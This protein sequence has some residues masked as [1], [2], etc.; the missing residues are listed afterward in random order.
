MCVNDFGFNGHDCS[1]IIRF[2]DIY[3][4][5]VPAEN[6]LKTTEGIGI[7]YEDDLFYTIESV[8]WLAKGSNDKTYSSQAGSSFKKGYAYAVRLVLRSGEGSVFS[9]NLMISLNGENAIEYTVALSK[10]DNM[11]T[12]TVFAGSIGADKQISEVRLYPDVT[13]P[14]AGQKI[15]SFCDVQNQTG[16]KNLGQ[17]AW[18]TCDRNNPDSESEMAAWSTGNFFGGKYWF[19]KV[20]LKPEDG[21]T[22]G[23]GTD[24]YVNDCLVPDNC[25]LISYNKSNNSYSLITFI[26]YI[27]GDSDIS[28]VNIKNTVADPEGRTVLSVTENIRT[29]DETKISVNRT[30]CIAYA[31]DGSSKYVYEDEKIVKGWGYKLR[32]ILRA[33]NGYLFDPDVAAYID[34]KAAG[35]ENTRVSGDRRYLYVDIDY[36]FFGETQIISRVDITNIPVK[37]WDSDP[38]PVLKPEIGQKHISIL[39]AEW[40]HS[41]N[42]SNWFSCGHFELCDPDMDYRVVLK[43]KADYG[44]EI[45]SQNSFYTDYEQQQIFG[46]KDGNTYLVMI[47]VSNDARISCI[48]E[49]CFTGVPEPEYGKP[50]ITEGPVKKSGIKYT[51]K[52][53]YNN[54]SSSTGTSFYWLYSADGNSWKDFTGEYFEAGYY[55]CIKFSGEI[56]WTEYK[57]YNPDYSDDPYYSQAFVNGVRADKVETE[58]ADNTYY[59]Y[60]F[61]KY[62][63]L[64]K[65]AEALNIV[66]LN[67]TA[68]SKDGEIGKSVPALSVKAAKVTS[69]AWTLAESGAPASG[70]FA[71]GKNYLLTVEIEPSAGFVFTPMTRVLINGKLM[72]I[73]QSDGKITAVLS[74]NIEDSFASSE[75][76]GNLISAKMLTPPTKVK[77]KKG[78]E[79]V[80]GGLRIQ[81]DYE[82]GS[83]CYTDGEG[84]TASIKT[85]SAEGKQTV[86]L[87]FESYIFKYEITVEKTATVITGIE[88]TK[89]PAKTTYIVGERLRTAGMEVT[90]HTTNG[91]RIFK[92][93]KNIITTPGI[94]ST[95]G[96]QAVTV[97]FSGKRC[98]FNVS[99]SEPAATEYK[100]ISIERLP[101]RTKYTE[102]ELPDL[103]GLIVKIITNKDPVILCDGKD[104]TV[105]GIK[106]L[107]AGQNKIVLEYNGLTAEFEIE[108]VAGESDKSKHIHSKGEL[109]AESPSTCTKTGMKAHYVCET[110]GR[111]LNTDE[112]AV[113]IEEL[114]FPLAP[115]TVSDVWSNNAEFHWKQCS[116]CNTVLTARYEHHFIKDSESC[117][118]CGYIKKGGT[119]END[120]NNDN[121][122]NNENS[123][124][125]KSESC[126]RIWLIILIAVVAVALT[127]TIICMVRKKKSKENQ[128]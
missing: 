96:E 124:G 57:W 8:K 112:T 16:Y 3:G 105:T 115:H 123:N 84:V 19:L 36:G 32:I 110:C 118:T 18:M 83:K 27:S 89:L 23:F 26:K 65:D 12:V 13:D 87:S 121:N 52:Y 120:N 107:T 100:S 50:V 125:T 4:V 47:S 17:N 104:I 39:S 40:Q 31:P 43:I 33:E 5:P 25:Y 70:K 54:P 41:E 46:V 92:D 71:A 113:P 98:S 7:Y 106:P 94:F 85:A 86:S 109:I 66:Q 53:L 126:S 76:L 102:G 62:G 72:S 73:T 128:Q 1:K 61:K 108:A 56:N 11:A 74:F 15:N 34:G 122:N 77:Y 35:K 114:I 79:I 111:Y 44:Y 88:L 101:F 55:Y 22:F 97:H 58:E 14:Q 93:G 30:D 6:G 10:A 63:K 9:D 2:I 81:A 127:V 99:V 28:S 116:V 38:L 37:I 82:N 51:E 45:K 24:I 59:I 75:G 60:V 69:Y 48:D 68:P 67:M 80:L 20:S 117:E 21:Y 119:S 78:E 90:V 91:D 95:E 29:D 64:E 42:G 103:T 49:L